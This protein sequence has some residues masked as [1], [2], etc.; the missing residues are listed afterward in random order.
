MQSLQFRFALLFAAL[1]FL[2]IA[3]T[4]QVPGQNTNMVSGTT[5]PTGDPY[6]QRQN[7]PSIA[8]SS[9]NSTRLLAGANDYRSVSIPA[10]PG[11]TD[12]TGDA[13]LGVFK[14]FDG[15]ATWQ[16]N[17]LPGYPQDTSPTGMS[18]PLHGFTTGADPV[19]R[20][21]TNGMFYYSGIAFNRGTNNGVVFVARY[22][23]LANKENGDSIQY[24]DAAVVARGKTKQF[25]D[26]PSMAVDISRG[27]DICTIQTNQNGTLVTQ[28]IPAGH[29][30]LTYTDFLEAPTGIGT[31]IFVVRSTDCGGTWGTPVRVSGGVV[32]NQ[33]STLA[34]DPNTGTVYVAWREFSTTTAQNAILIAKST[35]G[36]Y[37]FSRIA[38][39]QSLPSFDAIKPSAPSFFD[40]G[41]TSTSFR[42]NAYPT[43]AVDASS[44]IY[45]AWSQRGVNGSPDA[46][47]VLT[48][49]AD[50]VN[51]SAPVPVDNA[52]ITDDAGHPFS[53]GHQLM[54]SLT[55]SGGKVMVLYYDLRLDHSV[56]VFTPNFP[57][58][59]NSGGAFYQQTRIPVPGSNG[60]VDP[61]SSVLSPFI[62]DAGLGIRHTLDVRISQADASASPV[63]TSAAVSQYRF[64]T[65]GDVQSPSDLT[66][67][68]LQ[69]NPPN[70]PMFQGGTVPF[71][72]DYIEIS[73]PSFRSPGETGAGWA[74]NAGTSGNPVG[75]ATWTS[76]QDVR[77]PLNF[78]WT[79]T[80]IPD[81]PIAPTLDGSR[82]QNIYFSRINQGFSLTAPQQSKPLSTTLQRAFVLE[83]FNSTDRPHSFSLTVLNQPP[84][85]AASFAV[86]PT[87][88]P[89]PLPPPVQS[90][91]LTLPPRSGATRSIFLSSSNPL[92]P[93]TVQASEIPNPGGPPLTG[94]PLGAFVVLN[95]DPS[96]PSLIDPDNSPGN[97]SLVEL[98]TPNLSNPN[99]SNPNISNPNT[100]NPN[101]SNPNISNPNISN[102]NISNPNISNPN[103]SNPNIS[104]PNI[105]NP[106]ISNPNISNPNISNTPVS[107]LSYT[108]TNSGNTNAAYQVKLIQIGTIVP[109]N[110][111]LQLI[112]SKNYATPVAVGCQ[113]TEE[114]NNI[115]ITNVV[116]PNFIDYTQIGTNTS[117]DPDPEKN[118]TLHLAPGETAVLTIRGLVDQTTMQGISNVIIPEVRAQAAVSQDNIS[119]LAVPLT[120]VPANLPNALAGSNYQATFV[121]F[122]GTAPYTWFTPNGLPPGFSIDPV[123]GNISA[124][125][126]TTAGTYSF[127][128]KITDAAG[129]SKTGTYSLIVV[130]PLT[131]NT[132]TLPG[133][134][135][136][137]AYSSTVTATGGLSPLTWTILSGSLPPG[138]TLAAQTGTLTGSP[139]TVGTYSFTVQANDAGS[140]A[141]TTT[142][143]YTVNITNSLNAT[144]TVQP[145]DIFANVQIL[146]PIKVVVTDGTGAPVSGARVVLTIEVNPGAS[147]L[148]GSFSE[149]TGSTGIANFGT[150]SLDHPGVGYRLRATAT[151]LTGQTTY[152]ISQLLTVY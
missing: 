90:V 11:V 38:T 48:S 147:V 34:I 40:Q 117:N 63:F 107:D 16:S 65:L 129:A 71:M 6:L 135:V 92:A 94:S 18:S 29:V 60:Q 100:A 125:S 124:Y 130:G 36:G 20:A 96:V 3:A 44:R 61:P 32:V 82:N 80:N 70:L 85:G 49:S 52:T 122:G 4:A 77:P 79:Q 148:T 51:W 66:L 149:P 72:G 62:S 98:Y 123:T 83:L 88:L 12:E 108:I 119:K 19:V 41:L 25:L 103:I 89:S 74:F 13:W 46:R 99:I 114:N 50:A 118:P 113:L 127:V 28:T 23:D 69:V 75:Y 104:N 144:F 137:A 143:A 30:Y 2:D 126:S 95:A 10:P 17:L 81:C 134:I 132:A 47:V 112:L 139:T 106:N 27:H 151:S 73:G 37:T 26:K 9:R 136:N 7:E 128:L 142:H 115:P 31:H 131:I 22:M 8:A 78:D 15:G 68:Q 45:L 93:V 54:P 152:V 120:L 116:S 76:N 5:F 14:S 21:G 24:L 64:G 59:P 67:H 121:A 150:D 35:D 39:V 56:G 58:V 57:F 102:P 42:T 55:V 111:H 101:I 146:P 91:M 53:R 1:T 84:G 87:P 109:S 133:G 33:G 141:Q 145:S 140:P 110:P 97:I 86:A 43:L 138:V 105:S